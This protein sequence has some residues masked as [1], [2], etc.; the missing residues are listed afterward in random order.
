[1]SEHKHCGCGH[2]HDHEEHCTCGHDHAHEEHCGCGCEHDH[3]DACGC[4]CGHD[5][6]GEVNKTMLLRVA[7]CV[8]LLIA[9]KLLEHRGITAAAIPAYL[10]AYLLMGW[11]VLLRA[12]RNLVR[13]RVFDENFLM[14]VATLGALWI[15]D[16]GEAVFVM[17]FYQVGE[18]CQSYAVGRSRKSIADLMDIRPETVHLERDGTEVTLSPEEA[19]PGDIMVVHPG[20]RIP[21]DG[22]VLDGCSALDTSALT[23]EATPRDVAAGDG[24]ISGCINR[25]GVL[26]IR[27]ERPYREST[28]ARILE[29][30]ENAGSRKAERE[31]FITRFAR[32]YTPCVVFA[33]LALAVIPPLFVGGWSSWSHRA[34]TF[35]VVSCP[36]ALVLSVPLS[37]FGGVGGASR[38]GILVKGSCYLERLAEVDTVVLDKT[39]TLTEGRFSVAEICPAEGISE[40]YLLKLAALAENYSQH[41]VALS[42][43]EACPE[44]VDCRITDAKEFPGHGVAAEVNG[45]RIAAGNHRLMSRAGVIC[46]EPDAAGTVVHVAVD[47]CYAGYLVIAD[48][49]RP[50]AKETVAQLKSCGVKRIVMLTGDGEAAASAVAAELG[51]TEYRAG[52]LPGDKVACMEQ[53]LAG[54]SGGSV[55]FVGDGIN[56]APVLAR[57]DVGIAMGALGSDAAVEAADVVLMDDNLPKI[58]EAVRISRRTLAIVRQNIAFALCVK[59]LVLALSALGKAGMGAAVFADV[60]VALLT[61]LNAARALRVKKG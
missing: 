5:H 16:L 1:M 43:K 57:A 53:I 32:V 9:A 60:G 28:V 45:H 12:F 33:A 10:I 46:E 42:L 26:R 19:V 7:G 24:V 52:L 40:G 55:T 51:I 49:V 25:T 2:E 59:G 11:D 58:A 3:E 6:S 35:L 21:L 31:A 18:L 8:L 4:G 36:C 48:R 14:S 41:P 34:L 39:G 61:I 13:G 17:L 47:G 29:L 50:E 56:D 20:E 15:G 22:T 23:G 37:F 54:K 30:V 27:V 38:R 44:A